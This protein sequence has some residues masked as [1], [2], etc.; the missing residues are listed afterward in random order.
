M[1][2]RSFESIREVFTPLL[3]EDGLLTSQGMRNILERQSSPLVAT[4]HMIVYIHTPVH[5]CFQR[6][7]SRCQPGDSQVTMNYLERIEQRH[8]A[9]LE[10]DTRPILRLDGTQRFDLPQIFQW[11]SHQSADL[12][13]ANELADWF[14][15]SP[16]T[17]KGK[18]V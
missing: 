2:E 17:H 3:L 15:N 6:V 7:K 18:E 16:Q 4:E 5:T 9:W 12:P 13:F 10:R 14:E 8:I 1:E 11:I